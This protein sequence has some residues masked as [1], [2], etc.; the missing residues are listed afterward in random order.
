MQTDPLLSDFHTIVLDEFHERSLHGDLALALAKQAWL[1]RSDLRLVV[2]SATLDAE[3][4][5]RFLDG[6][7][8]HHIAGRSYPLEISYAPGRS[9]VDC[10]ESLARTADGARAVLPARCR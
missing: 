8:I 5:S 3:P 7:P 10:A 6:C 9:L 1:A 4:V 2:M